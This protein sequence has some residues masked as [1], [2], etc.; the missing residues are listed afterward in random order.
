MTSLEKLTVQASVLTSAAAPVAVAF[1]LRVLRE[2]EG[3][4]VGW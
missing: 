2:L 3:H 4:L 1:G